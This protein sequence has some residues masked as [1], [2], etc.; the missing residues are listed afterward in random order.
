[1]KSIYKFILVFIIGLSANSLSAQS[2]ASDTT[3]ATRDTTMLVNGV[4]GMC[5]KTIETALYKL[6]GLESASW[7]KDTKVLQLSYDERKLSLEQINEQIN[8]AGYDTEYSTA[9][10]ESY[11]E[12]DPCCHYR[13]P[14]V[15]E[16]HK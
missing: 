10:N 5:K 15:V 3:V 16:D 8:Q 11:A 13:D 14:K 4:C 2:Q 1:M 12:L 9:D 7:N 6:D